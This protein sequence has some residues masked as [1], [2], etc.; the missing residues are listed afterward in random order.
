MAA[1]VG[2]RHLHFAAGDGCSSDCT[3][4]D[5]YSCGVGWLDRWGL[6]GVYA[7]LLA[8]EDRWEQGQW[9]KATKR[10]GDVALTAAPQCVAFVGLLDFAVIVVGST[11]IL[12]YSLVLLGAAIDWRQSQGMAFREEQQLAA[13][14]LLI[15]EQTERA[16]EDH[17]TRKHGP[18]DDDLAD[19]A[20]M[21]SKQRLPPSDGGGPAP[22]SEPG[23]GG[24]PPKLVGTTSGEG[25]SSAWL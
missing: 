12:Y 13:L 20:T 24:S 14:D 9:H 5:G 23:R 11:A 16:Y 4:E 15:E 18:S 3:V 19:L 7:L 17:A 25:G 2:R 8:D 6:R 10:S 22:E 1:D 21:E